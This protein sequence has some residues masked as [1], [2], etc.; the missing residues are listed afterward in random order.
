MP[1]GHY[2]DALPIWGDTRDGVKLAAL[3]IAFAVRQ[4]AC[5]EIHSPGVAYKDDFISQPFGAYV[6]MEYGSVFVNDEFRGSKIF[7]HKSSF[8]REGEK[9]E[10]EG[11]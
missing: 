10:L 5:Y 2:G 3:H 8:L 9:G 7:S 4:V 6:K 11:R 1:V